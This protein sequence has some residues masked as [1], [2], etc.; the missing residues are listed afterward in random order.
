MEV[1][2]NFYIHIGG[3][4]ISELFDIYTLARMIRFNMKKVIIY[5]GAA[6]IDNIR[7]F[8]TKELG[9]QITT[10]RQSHQEGKNFQCIDLRGTPQPWF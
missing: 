1:Y 7:N 9:Y 6:H 5:A 4:A 3:L 10:S 2:K 8:M